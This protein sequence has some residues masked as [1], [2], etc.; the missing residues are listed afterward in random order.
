MFKYTASNKSKMI[1]EKKKQNDDEQQQE[2]VETFE[3][4]H[5]SKD[6]SAAQNQNR[7]MKPAP[8][9]E[10]DY[11]PQINQKSKNMAREVNIVDLLEHDA[12]RRQKRKV[13]AEGVKARVE[14][15]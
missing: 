9:A 5:Q 15:T 11:H 1:L 13:D 6:F 12:Q 14:Q 7:I 8:R 2:E 4:L 3:R 10:F